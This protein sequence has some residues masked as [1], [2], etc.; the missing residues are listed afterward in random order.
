MPSLLYGQDRAVIDFVRHQLQ[1]DIEDFGVASAIGVV[2]SGQIIAGVVYNNYY[3][4]DIQASIAAVKKNWASH[5]ILYGLFAY[6]FLQLRCSR[7]TAQTRSSNK[8]AQNFLM[9]LGF[10]REGALRNWYGEDDAVIFGLLRT[11]CRW[12]KE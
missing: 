9:R 8:H 11:E 1:N 5:K 7:M 6:P 4:R 3:G 2:E 10:E 12:I